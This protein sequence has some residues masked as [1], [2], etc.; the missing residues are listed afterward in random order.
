MRR[1]VLVIGAVGALMLGIASSASA[2]SS[3]PPSC[4]GRINVAGLATSEPGA[5][6]DLVQAGQ[7]T[8]NPPGL[9]FG[10]EVGSQKAACALP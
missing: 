9:T 4:F 1:L 3:N 2:E 6:G 5:V 7:S 10:D 8:T